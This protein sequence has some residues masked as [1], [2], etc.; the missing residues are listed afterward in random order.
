MVIFVHSKKLQLRNLLS[1]MRFKVFCKSQFK[2]QS[3]LSGGV[4]TK[5]FPNFHIPVSAAVFRRK[6]DINDWLV[7]DHNFEKCV[8]KAHRCE[9]NFVN[10]LMTNQIKK[11]IGCVAGD[12]CAVD[13]ERAGQC[14]RREGSSSTN[15]VYFSDDR[16]VDRVQRRIH[17]QQHVS[18]LNFT[19]KY[20]LVIRQFHSAIVRR[21][22]VVVDQFENQMIGRECQGY[23]IC[24]YYFHKTVPEQIVPEPGENFRIHRTTAFVQVQ[25]FVAN[26]QFLHG[27]PTAARFHQCITW[28]TTRYFF[29]IIFRWLCSGR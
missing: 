21:G 22:T 26:V 13:D 29:A 17:L 9:N 10:K 28:K 19:G 14:S 7:F 20:G 2:N 1:M 3:V 25:H 8:K 12:Q 15:A 23:S 5:P 27:F 4:V 24:G 16:V 18:F 11:P 6:P